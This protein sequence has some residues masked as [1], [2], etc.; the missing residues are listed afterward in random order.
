[1]KI[2]KVEYPEEVIAFTCSLSE[3]V[4]SRI[5]DP[6]FDL[7]DLTIESKEEFFWFTIFT[8]V[9]NT[10]E[11]L[12]GLNIIIHDIESFPTSYH[13]YRSGSVA[14]RFE[15]FLRMFF[16][17]FYRFRETNAIILGALVKQEVIDKTISNQVKQTFHETF[18]QVIKIRNKMVH[19]KIEWDSKDHQIL[20]VYD[21]L[22]DSGYEMKHIETGKKLDIGTILEKRV[23]DFLPLMIASTEAA[24]DFVHTF[25]N[26][27]CSIY[28]QYCKLQK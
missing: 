18:E 25:A 6:D 14:T 9:T 1:M 22:A 28:M 23:S 24:R 20:T 3:E 16:H 15:L 17:E 4:K 10:N 21:L 13:T 26:T 8:W 19:D 11:I 5:E 2:D 27:T 12:A 7:S